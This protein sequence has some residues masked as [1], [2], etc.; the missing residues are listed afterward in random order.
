MPIR[1]EV[2]DI[3]TPEGV[4]F[5][6]PDIP[7]GPSSLRPPRRGARHDLNVSLGWVLALG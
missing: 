5:N 4:A 6:S 7:E 1:F 2:V 3:W